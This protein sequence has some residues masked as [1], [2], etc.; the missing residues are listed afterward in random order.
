[1]TPVNRLHVLHKFG[2]VSQVEDLCR[3]RYVNVRTLSLELRAS[4]LFPKVND[5]R[6]TPHVEVAG[7]R[8]SVHN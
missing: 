8:G 7:A 2:N 6:Q 1:V 4:S 5:P 3:Y